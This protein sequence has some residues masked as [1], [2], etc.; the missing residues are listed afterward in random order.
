MSNLRT[1]EPGIA[2][3]KKWESLHDGDLTK[4]GL[5]PKMCP[6]GIWTVGWGH[7]IVYDGKFLKGEANKALAY[8]LYPA[9][10]IPEAEAILRKDLPIPEN[11]VNALNLPFTQNQFNALV[12]FVYNLGFAALLESTLL[13]VIR[14][15]NGDI[16]AAFLM[17]NK[18]TM[19]GVKVPL[20]GLTSRRTEEAKLYQS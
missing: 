2:I 12:S 4:I 18:A 5:Q 3:I 10:T 19:N 8:S 14:N 6:A 17:W 13:K 20:P 11:Q 9:M 15:R 7:A 1:T 16:A